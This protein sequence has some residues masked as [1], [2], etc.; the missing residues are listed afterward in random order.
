MQFGRFHCVCVCMAG[1][2][3]EQNTISVCVVCEMRIDMCA[4]SWSLVLVSTLRRKYDTRVQ[5]NG[6]VSNAHRPIEIAYNAI[7]NVTHTM[8]PRCFER[9]VCMRNMSVNRSALWRLGH[10]FYS[11]HFNSTILTIGFDCLSFPVEF[12]SNERCVNLETRRKQSVLKLP[13]F[14]N[15]QNLLL[16]LWSPFTDAPR[17]DD[18]IS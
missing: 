10:V 9:R 5:C 4:D 6:Y 12:A 3:I 1:R 8:P 2:C 18:N 15:R 11:F 13:K 14:F 17:D 16:L 7:A